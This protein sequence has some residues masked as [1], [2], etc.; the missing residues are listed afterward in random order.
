MCV[1]FLICAFWLLVAVCP[2]FKQA[3]GSKKLTKQRLELRA[4]RSPYFLITGALQGSQGLVPGGCVDDGD[5]TLY[6]HFLRCRHH[7][8]TWHSENHLTAHAL[9]TCEWQLLE[10]IWRS[11]H[12]AFCGAVR[13]PPTMTA[14]VWRINLGCPR[15]ITSVNQVHMIDWI[16]LSRIITRIN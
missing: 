9:A 12:M 14:S 3:H 7:A 16:G 6:N 11:D 1:R 10:S 4:P 13:C 8:E 5:W 2:L 15:I